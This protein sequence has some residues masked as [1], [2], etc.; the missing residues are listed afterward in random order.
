MGNTELR[1]SLASIESEIS[2]V[3]GIALDT[4]AQ[5][6]HTNGT[7]KWQTK[8]IYTFLGALPLIT[9]WAGWLTLSQLHSN[10]ELAR[11]QTQDSLTK[12]QIQ[13]AA[14]EGIVAGLEAIS[15]K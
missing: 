4:H 6:L 11:L 7:V 8:M 13:Q 1:L 9:G 14:Q 3:K 10:D 5:A 15:N 2:D 12:E